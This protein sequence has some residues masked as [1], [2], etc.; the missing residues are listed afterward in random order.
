[1]AATATSHKGTYWPYHETK[2]GNMV[3]CANNPCRL[4]GESDVVARSPEEAYQKAAERKY[5]KDSMEGLNADPYNAEDEN[6]NSPQWYEGA[7]ADDLEGVH[8]QYHAPDGTF[9]SGRMD[10]SGK[11]NGQQVLNVASKGGSSTVKGKA[12]GIG[13]ITKTWDE[14]YWNRIDTDEV[15]KGDSVVVDGTSYPVTGIRRPSTGEKAFTIISSRDDETGAQ[16]PFHFSST[17]V[18]EAIR[19]KT[20]VDA[21]E[22]RGVYKGADGNIWVCDIYGNLTKVG[23][24]QGTY[25]TY[26]VKD[27]N[28]IDPAA[29]PFQRI[30]EK[31]LD[32][33]K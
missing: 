29:F 18:S 21:P 7:S 12:K 31:T 9:V 13:F 23:G 10:S 32:G 3:P 6:Y 30:S 17:K 4:H 5:G 8:V 16:K 22:E 11:V 26:V 28:T 20:G 14:R 25:S 33:L 1:M 2:D 27:Q 19:R 15:K 24:R